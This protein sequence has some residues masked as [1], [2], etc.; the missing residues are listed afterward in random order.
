[1][2]WPTSPP[3]H[4][5]Q[6]QMAI[7]HQAPPMPVPTVTNNHVCEAAGLAERVLTRA[8][9][10]RRST[11]KRPV[12]NA[13]QRLGDWKHG[14]LRGRLGSENNGAPRRDRRGRASRCRWPGFRESAEDRDRQAGG[15]FSPQ[16]GPA[17]PR[18]RLGITPSATMLPCASAMT[19]R[20]LVPPKSMPATSPKQRSPR[21]RSSG[22]L[23]LGDLPQYQVIREGGAYLD[24]R[25]GS[26]AQDRVFLTR[27]A[28]AARR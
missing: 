11:A 1:V 25:L 12:R 2:W 19:L 10:R 9:M 5:L 15:K 17:L 3:R 4:K 26:F 6:A 16:L 22:V 23:I 8:A 20:T 24:G 14:P 13:K 21:S 28:M 27:R 18:Q 7:E